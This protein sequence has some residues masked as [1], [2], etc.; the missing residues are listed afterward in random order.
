[1]QFAF[2]QELFFL[3]IKQ[4][5]GT[6]KL[7][8]LYMHQLAAGF[9]SFHFAGFMSTG[10]LMALNIHTIVFWSFSKLDFEFWNCQSKGESN[11]YITREGE[12][13]YMQRDS[14]NSTIVFQKL[15]LQSWKSVK[16]SPCACLLAIMIIINIDFMVC[17][18]NCCSRE[19]ILSRNKCGCWFFSAFWRV[20]WTL[21][22]LSLTLMH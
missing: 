4:L 5:K 16:H 1:M 9:S 6:S 15:E 21:E 20:V 19:L 7:Q 3:S 13:I 22:I 11:L 18:I 14:L 8:P 2:L 12:I 10:E 17:E